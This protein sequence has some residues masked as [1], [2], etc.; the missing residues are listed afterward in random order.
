MISPES[1]TDGQL[2]QI[3]VELSRQ[4]AEIE[5]HRQAIAKERAR[6]MGRIATNVIPFPRR[7]V[8]AEGGDAS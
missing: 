2:L 1:L 8:F 6:R 3:D 5:D 4:I 7:G